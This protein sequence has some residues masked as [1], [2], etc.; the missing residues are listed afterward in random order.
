MRHEER[1]GHHRNVGATNHA[2]Q[3][4]CGFFFD[5]SDGCHGDAIGTL[6][7]PRCNRCRPR[8]Y[9]QRFV[10][11]IENAQT[12]SAVGQHGHGN[13]CDVHVLTHPGHIDVAT[14]AS[15]K[16][17]PE[18]VVGRDTLIGAIGNHIV[19]EQFDNAH[20]VSVEINAVASTLSSLPSG[21]LVAG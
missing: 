15:R 11:G 9:G 2:P 21:Q 3:S 12:Q 1:G 18:G 8:G 5:R 14:R 17:L 7:Q 20:N 10:D 6:E 19:V 4:G 13:A 16:E